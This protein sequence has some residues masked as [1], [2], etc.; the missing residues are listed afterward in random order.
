MKTLFRLLLITL[1][2]TGVTHDSWAQAQAPN[3]QQ[4][5]SPVA[6]GAAAAQEARQ[7]NL[8]A[9]VSLK[10]RVVLSKYQGDKRISTLPYDMTVRTDSIT[11]NIRM[12]TQ[13][14]VRAFGAS[15]P[16]ADPVA[17]ARVGP[18]NYRDVGTS[19]DCTATN[20]DAGRFAVNLSIDDYSIFKDDERKP[21]GSAQ[22]D[23]QPV[24][25]RYQAKNNLVMRDG[26]STELT[27]AADKVTGEVVKAEISISVIK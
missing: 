25:R 21:A 24:L 4:P 6:E 14:P 9:I 8:A 27:V 22:V 16:A 5:K 12:N 19:I 17:A 26:Q 23:D 13:V 20:L 18:F 15:N 11:S 10:V 2:L 7:R 3:P 1:A